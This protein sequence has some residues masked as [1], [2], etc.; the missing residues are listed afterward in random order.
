MKIRE[1][2]W[3]DLIDT[4]Y[5]QEYLIL[6][7]EKIENQNKVID[8]MLMLI[9]FAGIFGW[10][11][12]AE[13]NVFWAFLLALLNG[14]RI[15]KTKFLV[16][17]QEISNLKA[18]YEFYVDHSRKLENLWLNHNSYRIDE[19][20]AE[21]LFEKYRDE[22]RLASKMYKHGKVKEQKS[23]VSKARAST[24]RYLTKIS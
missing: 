13:Y 12:F 6:Y 24:E 1:R 5:K 15:M 9:T 7:Y 17:D 2:I 19:H 3:Y 11:K 16:P 21:E 8:N 10:Y 23:L 20:K 22:E 18:V 4:K 14:F